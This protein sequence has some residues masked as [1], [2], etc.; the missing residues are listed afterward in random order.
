LVVA[1]PRF[2]VEE[3]KH[4]IETVRVRERSVR[5]FAP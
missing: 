4:L 5:F 3:L 1:H 2:C